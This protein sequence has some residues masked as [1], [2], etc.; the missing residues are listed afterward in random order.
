MASATEKLRPPRKAKTSTAPPN[1]WTEEQRRE[2]S[3]I[4]YRRFVTR[5]GEHGYHM[6]DWLEAERQFAAGASAPK[7]RRSAASKS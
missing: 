1:N 4:A 2:I 3:E 7:R 5:G 6:E